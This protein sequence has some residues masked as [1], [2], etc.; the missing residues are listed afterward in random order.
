MLPPGEKAAAREPLTQTALTQSAPQ[1]AQVPLLGALCLFLS[2]LEY[3]VPKPLPFMRAGLASLPLLLGLELLSPADYALL[4]LIKVTGQ[5]LITGT[6][7]SYV[8]LFSLAGTAVSAALMFLLHR[9]FR[10]GRGLIGFFGL[11]ILGALA[12]NCAQLA[13]ARVFVFGRGIRFFVPPFLIAGIVS[14]GGLG[15]FCEAFTRRSE[16]YKQKLRAVRACP[17][18]LRLIRGKSANVPD[19]RTAA[20]ALSVYA[21]VSGLVMALVFLFTPSLAGRACQFLFFWLLAAV[22][23]KK[24]R[25]LLT[26]FTMAA[27]V[28][29]GLA[30]PYGLAIARLGPLVIT[31]GALAAG[32]GKALSLEGLIMLSRVFVRR[33][34]PLP[35]GFGLLLRESLTMLEALTGRKGAFAGRGFFGGLDQLLMEMEAAGNGAAQ[36]ASA[37]SPKAPR[38]SGAADIALPAFAAAITAAL[39]LLR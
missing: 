2:T 6:L 15:L 28:L 22:M 23:G 9:C 1:A 36:A 31:E 18:S 37:V 12:S 21:A 33:D 14:G 27:V 3:L 16:W 34:L 30:A 25:P 4:A 19:A 11:G 32:L 35:G 24:T 8:F 38:G 20:H 29:C 7:A 5:A 26:L 17:L 39:G 13:L 10:R